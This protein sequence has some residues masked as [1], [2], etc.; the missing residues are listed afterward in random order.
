MTVE[1][2]NDPVLKRQLC[3]S[4]TQ[5]MRLVRRTPRFGGLPELMT[6]EYESCGLSQST[7]ISRPKQCGKARRRIEPRPAQPIDRAVAAHQSRSPAVANQ[8]I[9]FD[10][11]RHSLARN[12]RFWR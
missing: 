11:Q 12:K 9:V 5:P 4:C 3:P 7:V 1:R 10:A 2:T 6:F 8:C